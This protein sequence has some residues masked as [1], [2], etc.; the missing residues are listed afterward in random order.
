[1]TGLITINLEI[2]SPN[3]FLLIVAILNRWLPDKNFVRNNTDVER[4]SIVDLYQVK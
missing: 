3:D 1:M 2:V 4:L